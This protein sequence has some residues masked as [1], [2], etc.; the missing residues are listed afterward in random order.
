VFANILKYIGMGA[1]SSFGN[2]FSVLGASIFVP[3]LPMTP[4]QILTN[5]LLYDVSQTAIP[6]DA[7][8]PEQIAKPRPWDIG[9]IAKFI[10]FIGPCSSIF[11]YTTFLIMLYVF[12]AWAVEKAALFQT[13][14]FVES[15]LTQTLIVHVIRTQRVPFL[16]SRAS[17]A[18][19]A[20]TAVIMSIGVIVPST[21]LG[22]YLGFVLLPPG[23]WLL[24]ALTLLAYMLLTQGV[25]TWLIRR[26]WM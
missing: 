4:I 16:Q 5:N 24:L 23:Y 12:N 21:P 15:L 20:M 2:M 11:D 3:Y 19:I 22:R 13:G 10:L 18:L 9:A 25:K 7:V 26:A 6:T 17:G 8:D 14:W 1:S